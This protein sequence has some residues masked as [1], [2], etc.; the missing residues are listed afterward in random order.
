MCS[1]I[2]DV[3]CQWGTLS[4]SDSDG[5]QYQR[6]ILLASK[7]Y[8]EFQVWTIITTT[9]LVRTLNTV[10]YTDNVAS[11]ILSIFQLAYDN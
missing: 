1:I 3:W 6:G 4:V 2:S 11:R 9:S 5:V 7:K 8:I 10:T